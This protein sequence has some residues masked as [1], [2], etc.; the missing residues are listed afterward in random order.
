LARGEN[1]DKVTSNQ[2]L[3]NEWKTEERGEC[4]SQHNFPA[5]WEVEAGTQDV[6]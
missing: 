3:E 6:I 4:E 1:R 5:S 2:A